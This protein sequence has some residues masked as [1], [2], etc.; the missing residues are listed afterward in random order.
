MNEETMAQS[1]RLVT[2]NQ[3]S[4]STHSKAGVQTQDFNSQGKCPVFWTLCV[5]FLKVTLKT[6]QNH[7][8]SR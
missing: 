7:F 1:I 8:S 4:S 3:L 6:N 2:Q 5:F